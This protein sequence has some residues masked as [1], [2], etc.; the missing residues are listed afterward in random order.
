PALSGCRNSLSPSIC[1][2]ALAPGTIAPSI[3]VVRKI[4]FPQT[5]GEEWPRPA[6]GVFHLMF[7]VALHSVG[8]FFSVEIPCPP[9]PRHCGQFGAAELPA[10]EFRSMTVERRQMTTAML[11]RL[12]SFMLPISFLP[13][14][15]AL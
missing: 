14:I 7:L 12:N 13:R 3:A 4:L 11:I 10:V 8:R 1:L 6:I 5:M 15:A 2:T 9:G